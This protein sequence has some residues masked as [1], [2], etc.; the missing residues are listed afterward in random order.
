MTPLLNA[1]LRLVAETP[2]ARVDQLARVIAKSV[3]PSTAPGLDEWP[4]TPSAR[5]LL[6]SLV[7]A[8]KANPV[9]PAGL[10]ALLVGASVGYR[11]AKA[12]QELELVWTGPP[13]PTIATRRTEQALLEVIDAAANRLFVTSFVAYSVPSVMK[14]FERAI[15][16][17]VRLSMLLELSEQDGGGITFDVIGKMKAALPTAHICSW[18]NQGEKFAGGKVHAKIAVADETVCFVSSANLTG[19]AMERNMEA[20][21]LIRGGSVP[22]DLHRHLE[23]LETSNVIARV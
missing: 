7:T 3:S 1:V 8:W 5:V 4:L 2:P 9:E 12:E 21:V 13:G 18:T 15:A 6:T 10:A 17:G 23:A 14:A 16:R 20:G 22:R 19:H 11:H